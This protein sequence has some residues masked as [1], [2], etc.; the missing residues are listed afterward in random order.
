L[1][2]VKG[3]SATGETS[4]PLL[5]EFRF[6]SPDALDSHGCLIPG[7]FAKLGPAAGRDLLD[8]GCGNGA[9]TRTLAS[10]G[11]RTVGA[12]A[13]VSG[14]AMARRAHPDLD[15]EPQDINEALAPRL[16]GN[17]DVV[18][19]VE[20]IEHLFLPRRLFG[21][22]AEALRPGGRLV[23]STPYHGYLKNLAIAALNQS[24]KHWTVG[25]DHGHIKFFSRNTLTAMAL[26]QGFRPVD[27]GFVGRSRPLSKSMIMVAVPVS[28]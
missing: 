15:W 16:R 1:L 17:F 23:L 22:A 2:L 18:L 27:W 4:G 14:M 25:W 12:D 10:A 26:D 3:D 21:R 11:F 19:A 24:D 28:F 13:S 7:L 20:V 9:L 8:L 6:D 5:D